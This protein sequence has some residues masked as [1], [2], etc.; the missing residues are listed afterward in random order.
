MKTYWGWKYS[1]THSLTSILEE[2]EWSASR[3]GRFTSGERAPGTRWIGGWVG[4][5]AGLDAVEKR[6]IG[7]PAGNRTHETQLWILWRSHCFFKSVTSCISTSIY[8]LPLGIFKRQYLQKW[9]S[10]IRKTRTTQRYVHLQY[11]SSNSSPRR[12]KHAEKCKRMHRQ[13]LVVIFN[14]CYSRNCNSSRK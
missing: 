13:R 10:L 14:T 8:H 4:S 3:L 6:K 11:Y 7:I 12:I 5:R 9:P 1:S 2:G